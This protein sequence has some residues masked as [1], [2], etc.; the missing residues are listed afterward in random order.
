MV[1]MKLMKKIGKTVVTALMLLASFEAWGAAVDFKAEIDPNEIS[2][3]ESV[4][5]KLTIKISE[6]NPRLGEPQFEAPEFETINQFQSSQIQSVYENGKFQMQNSQQITFLLRPK[7]TGTFQI[8]GIS[9]MVD[10]HKVSA[11]PVSV[12]VT[13]GGRSSPPPK[14]YGG[15]VGTGSL[16][17]VSKPIAREPFTI[18]AEINKDTVYK[19]EQII[20]S[21]YLYRRTKVFNIQV[22]Q[23][24]VLSGF[25]RED[26]DVPVMGTQ[27]QSEEVV[28]DGVPYQRSLLARYAAYPLKEGELKI[29]SMSIKANY[30]PLRS[31]FSGMA[32]DEDM[33]PFANFFQQLNPL[34]Q[35]QRSPLVSIKVLPLPQNGRPDDFSGGVGAFTLSASV[36]KAQVKVNEAVNLTLKVEG[37]GNVSSMEA[38]KNQWPQGLELYESKGNSKT[39]RAGHA[40]K[41]FEYLL[42]P[43]SGGTVTIPPFEVAFFDPEKKQY[44][45]QKTAPIALLVDGQGQVSP[46]PQPLSNLSTN[47]GQ[48]TAAPQVAPAAPGF[49][50]PGSS[51]SPLVNWDQ[52]LNGLVA[53]VVAVFLG[54]FF[55]ERIRS[56]W[57]RLRVKKLSIDTQTRSR[58]QKLKSK[59]SQLQQDPW[60]MVA[61]YYQDLESILF[62][63]LDERYNISVR[64]SSRSELK[65]MIPQWNQLEPLFDFF[66]LVRFS[67]SSAASVEQEA[68]TSA[69]KFISQIEKI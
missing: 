45:R 26:L 8:H 31:R 48:N 21:Y 14:S 19:G 1:K 62:D 46:P 9:I 64:A 66:D 38:P 39:G 25:L 63:I 30:Y 34:A 10:G 69:L 51:R 7:K 32:G 58:L 4:S 33:D 61:K 17:G 23:Y 59:A 49:L 29:D 40:E 50:M 15:G 56:L 53:L 68:R 37:R 28:V 54:W 42:I 43:R 22:A 60:E 55:W 47:S 35:T 27:L 11:P 36:D 2:M 12:V 5:L 52:I 24:P 6:G 67:G 16:R 13:N 41:V 18:K 44:I 20:V 3:D 57:I 65:E